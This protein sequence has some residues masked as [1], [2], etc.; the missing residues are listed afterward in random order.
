[1]R[2]VALAKAAVAHGMADE[3]AVALCAPWAH[4]AIWRRWAEAKAALRWTGLA[5]LDLPA[6][7]V[8]GVR[9]AE[10]GTEIAARYR[11]G[12]NDP[13]FEATLND[14]RTLLADWPVGGLVVEDPDAG[15][16]EDRYTSVRAVTLEHDPWTPSQVAVLCLGGVHEQHYAVTAP[17]HVDERHGRSALRVV[18]SDGVRWLIPGTTLDLPV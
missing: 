13:L 6:D 4:R 15:R 10:Q 2:Q 1:M 18:S 16:P 12:P 3:A 11:L 9:H 7:A 5:L 14:V 17:L 8:A